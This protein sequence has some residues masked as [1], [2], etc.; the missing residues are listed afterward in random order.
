MNDDEDDIVVSSLRRAQSVIERVFPEW[1]KGNL[2][3]DDCTSI[4]L[5]LKQN[6]EGMKYESA[7]AQF[8]MLFESEVMPRLRWRVIKKEDL[9]HMKEVRHRRLDL[10]SMGLKNDEY[11]GR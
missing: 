2:D 10:R 5:Q 11:V 8:K 4:L 1:F 7:V 6:I 3:R 9:K